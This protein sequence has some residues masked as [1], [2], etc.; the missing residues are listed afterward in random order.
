[1]GHAP[2]PQVKI[3]AQCASIAP[4]RRIGLDAIPGRFAVVGGGRRAP[5][6]RPASPVSD[7]PRGAP[8]IV[9]H[10][11]QN[12]GRR[13]RVSLRPK[14]DACRRRP[15]PQDLGAAPA[16]CLNGWTPMLIPGM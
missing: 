11:P 10:Q 9:N 2:I 15:W 8:E 3:W 13:L 14:E 16:G 6:G 1:M 4:R 12:E 5:A 7:P